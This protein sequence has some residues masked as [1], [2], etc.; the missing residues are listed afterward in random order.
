MITRKL[1]MLIGAYHVV[2]PFWLRRSVYISAKP[3]PKFR[4]RRA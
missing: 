1:R 4:K 2:E 3:K